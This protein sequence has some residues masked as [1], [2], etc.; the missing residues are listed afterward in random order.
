MSLRVFTAIDLTPQVISDIQSFQREFAG[1]IPPIIR[2]TKTQLLHI[3]LRFTGALQENHLSSI[4]A[5]LAQELH[6]Q[7]P[8]SLDFHEAGV[9]PNIKSPRILWVGLAPSS[10]LQNL[11][12]INENIFGHYGYPAEKRPFQPH[13]TIGRFKEDCSISDLQIFRNVFPTLQKHFKTVQ[14]VDHLTFY[15][16]T[17]TPHGPLYKI[18]TTI[19]FHP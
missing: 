7:H 8:F 12:T 9:F 1:Q 5:Q 14:L 18:H 10:D 2:W 15:E 13:I 17:L 4:L 6:H 11:F 3:T 16:N 19:T